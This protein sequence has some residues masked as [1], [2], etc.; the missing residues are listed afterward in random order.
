MPYLLAS[1]FPDKPLDCEAAPPL[2]TKLIEFTGKGHNIP[3]IPASSVLADRGRALA[4][5]ISNR[6]VLIG[7]AYRAARDYYWTPG[8]Y[9]FGV[10]VVAHAVETEISGGRRELSVWE[11]ALV[12]FVTG[13]CFLLAAYMLRQPYDLILSGLAPVLFAFVGGW[14]FYNEFGFFIG[15]ASTML[16]VPIGVSVQHYV[17]HL[18]LTSQ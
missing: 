14:I 12:T 18:Q 9:M 15:L 1:V 3:T 2:Q 11:S 5:R 7:A 8:G 16:G 4:S 10:K 17:E 6:I 13:T